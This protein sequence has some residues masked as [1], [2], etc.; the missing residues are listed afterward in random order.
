MKGKKLVNTFAQ[1]RQKK[2][3]EEENLPFETPDELS[4]DHADEIVVDPDG[5][6]FFGSQATAK[7]DYIP[8]RYDGRVVTFCAADQRRFDPR[9]PE[10][11]MGWKRLVS[12]PLDYVKVPGDH[13]GM[14]REPN[15]GV[16]SNFIEKLFDAGENSNR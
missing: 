15:V 2:I 11:I 6:I 8:G 13:D 14:L 4:A 12:G 3:A 5:K 1:K 10:T 16:I 9:T 7:L